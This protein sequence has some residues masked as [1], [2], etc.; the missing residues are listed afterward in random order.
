MSEV[1]WNKEKRIETSYGVNELLS[2]PNQP[3]NHGLL[4]VHAMT[5]HVNQTFA[6]ASRI[7]FLEHILVLQV[8]EYGDTAGQFIIN[9]S[10]RD[11]FTGFL[12][13]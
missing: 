13:Q 5:L 1:D 10:L 2:K 4:H 9:F 3:V 6:K 7:K 8:F 12:Q 11:S